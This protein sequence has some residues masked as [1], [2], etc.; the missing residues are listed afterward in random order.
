MGMRQ[1][2]RKYNGS[3]LTWK[4][5]FSGRDHLLREFGDRKMLKKSDRD[6]KK[7]YWKKNERKCK[8]RLLNRLLKVG[9]RS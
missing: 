7:S 1:K 8:R 6:E 9:Q 4:D 5:S 2:Q 3:R